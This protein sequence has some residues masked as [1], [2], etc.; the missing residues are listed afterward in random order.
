MSAKKKTPEKKTPE[1]K[2]PITAESKV[3]DVVNAYPAALDALVAMGFT[4]LRNPIARRTVAKLFTLAQAASFKGVDLDQLLATVRRAAGQDAPG[5]DSPFPTAPAPA[6][7]GATPSAEAPVPRLEGDITVMG[8]VPCPVRGTL[9]ERFDAFSQEFSSTS[10]QQVAWW[11]A[12]E[13]TVIG[14]VRTWLAELVNN[15]RVEAELPDVFLAVGT[16]LFFHRTFGRLA[17]GDLF[18]PFPGVPTLRDDFKPYGDPA[19]KLGLQFCAAFGL[20][21]RPDR[22]PDGKLPRSWADLAD[23]ALHGE[24]AVPS[25]D[26]PIVPDLMAALR[27][28]LGDAF[29]GLVSNMAATMHPAQAAPRGRRDGVPGVVILPGLFAESSETTGA[30]YVIPEEGPIGVPGFVAVRKRARPEADRIVE[31]LFSDG[32][33]GPLWERGRFHPNSSRIDARIPNGKFVVRSWKRLLKGDP[34]AEASG[35][36][37]ELKA[38]GLK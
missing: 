12:G 30:T 20:S 24:V 37:A 22:L 14:D 19:G 27:D 2:V 31:Y 3:A 10:G 5:D 7:A 25:L 17:L 29:D 26:L 36:I 32:Y 34:E 38:R 1:K 21:C 15:D 28:H 13:G 4:P 8:L 33:L 11:L 6:E 35:L 9:V 23:P 18:R 16:E